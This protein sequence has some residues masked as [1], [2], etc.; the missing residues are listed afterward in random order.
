M[1]VMLDEEIARAVLIGDGRSGASNDKINEQNIRPIWT[2]ADLFT[3][4]K[5]VAGGTP[6]QVAENMIDDAVRARKNYQGSGNPVLFTTE[7]N[8]TEMLLLKDEMGHRLYKNE[9]ELATAMRV[10]RIVTVQVMENQTRSVT[11]GG[12]SKTATLQGI[13][14]NMNDY[15]IGADKGGAVSMFDDFDIDY[16]Q[17]KYLIETRCSGALIKPFSAIVIETA[18]SA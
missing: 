11:V 17:Q 1:R 4:K 15:T 9:S 12:E 14:V 2:D 6:A 13:I 18:Q 7:D 5:T 3:I 10:S 8:L 16:N